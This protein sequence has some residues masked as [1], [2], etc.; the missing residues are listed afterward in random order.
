MRIGEK[1][2]FAYNQ[3]LHK[4]DRFQQILKGTLGF[5]LQSLLEVDFYLRPASI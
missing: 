4:C 2:P 1:I 3:I 5:R